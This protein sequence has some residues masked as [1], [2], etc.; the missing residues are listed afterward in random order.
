MHWHHF[1]DAGVLPQQLGRLSLCLAF[2]ALWVPLELSPM[3]EVATNMACCFCSAPCGACL[4]CTHKCQADNVK[5]CRMGRHSGSSQVPRHRSSDVKAHLLA[6]HHDT[7][8]TCVFSRYLCVF[9]KHVWFTTL[10]R[11]Q[12]PCAGICSHCTKT[13]LCRYVQTPR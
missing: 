10:F 6:C 2:V 7:P 13:S 9:R 12:N 5:E 1:W 8:C 3:Q 11:S 4:L